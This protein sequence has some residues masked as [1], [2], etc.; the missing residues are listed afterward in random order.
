M[1]LSSDLLLQGKTKDLGGFQVTRLLPQ[2]HRRSLG[3][4]VFLDH[5]GP[6]RIDS[7][8]KLDVR[9][10]PHI[11]LATVTYLFQGRGF[12]RD[13]LGSQQVIEPGDINWMTAGKGI[14]HSERTPPEDLIGGKVIQGTQFWIALPKQF[15]ECEPE[16]LHY[17]KSQFPVVQLTQGVQVKVLIGNL[18]GQS[19]PVKVYSPTL[20]LDFNCQKSEDF[21]LDLSGQEIGFFWLDGEC[22]VSGVSLV[23]NTLFIPA[24]SQK[25]SIRS[26]PG[27]RFLIFGGEALS[28]PRFM[29]WNFVS[30]R[31]ERI[32]QAAA[33]WQDQ[34]MGQVTGESEWIP[35]PKDPLP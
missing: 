24:N 14:V 23:G 19:S 8:H 1:S 15:E 35:L 7:Q 4:F 16:F 17:P 29:W 27:A 6:M 30:S 21:Q 10:H 2:A 3:P 22:L 11:G 26:Q 28:E 12:H 32:R 5:M 13:S 31:K 33:D 18:L 20:F 34:K 9:P 25:I